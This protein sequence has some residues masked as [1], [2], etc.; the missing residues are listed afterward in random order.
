M[1]DSQL[2]RA[3]LDELQFE[4]GVNSAHF[5]VAVCDGFVTLTGHAASYAE[6]LAADKATKRLYDVKAVA[7]EI[8]IR[9]TTAGRTKDEDLAFGVVTALHWNA[10]V[11]DDRVVVSVRDGWVRLG[12]T[13]DRHFQR[14]AAEKAVRRLA[15]VIGVT[16]DIQLNPQVTAEQVNE[17]I[18]EAFRRNAELDAHGIC[19]R[20]SDGRV[21]L[22]GCARSALERLQA[23]AAAWSAPGV[24]E[25]KNE[26]II[27]P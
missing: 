4:P 18:E 16:N 1:N 6:R 11:P 7:N 10:L 13:L 2:Q 12:G 25:V 23:G 27:T 15:G 20:A 19:V 9:P 5:G 26:L 21:V 3:V 8:D 17:K 22:T 14:V 24:N